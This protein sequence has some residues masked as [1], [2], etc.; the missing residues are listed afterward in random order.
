MPIRSTFARPV[1]GRQRSVIFRGSNIGTWRLRVTDPSRVRP[2][3]SRSTRRNGAA[4]A[5]SSRSRR[6]HI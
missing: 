3:P 4:A 1:A 5:H 6:P 2:E